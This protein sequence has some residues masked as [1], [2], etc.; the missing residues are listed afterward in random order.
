MSKSCLLKQE[1]VVQLFID[2]SN[3]ESKYNRIIELGKTLAGI[4]DEE[5]TDEKRV[6]GCQSLMY[7]DAECVDGLMRYRADS[8]AL[9]SAGLASLLI[10]VYDG[11]S[12]ETVLKCPP[13]FLETLEIQSSITPSRANGLFS[14]HLQMKQ[15]ALKHLVSLAT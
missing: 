11:E 1:E 15:E 13:T 4:S 12:P 2:V 5:K 6:K 3:L 7:L 10:R 9:I 14:L 8:D